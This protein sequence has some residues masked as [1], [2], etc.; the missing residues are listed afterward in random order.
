M[1]LKLLRNRSGRQQFKT[2]IRKLTNYYSTLRWTEITNLIIND[3]WFR[4]ILMAHHWMKLAFCLNCVAGRFVDGAIGVVQWH[5]SRE[6]CQRPNFDDRTSSVLQI[7][8]ART[9]L[10]PFI[11]HQ[12][13]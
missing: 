9:H 10:F 12:R 7:P 5:P 2:K 11:N 8:T 1:S 4:I 6:V 13:W 3:I